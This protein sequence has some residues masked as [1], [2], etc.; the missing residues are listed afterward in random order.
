MAISIKYG[1]ESFKF[2][3]F[4]ELIVDE[5]KITDEAKV[6]PSG[7]AFLGMLHKKLIRQMKDKENERDKILNAKFIIYKSKVDDNTGRVYSKD[8]AEALAYNHQSHQVALREH[9]QAQEEANTI[10]VCV[11]SFEQRANLI[12]TISANLRRER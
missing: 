10:G 11:S 8:M 7:Y 9:L 5:N 1:N 12:Q 2:N 6:Q 3:L 4:K